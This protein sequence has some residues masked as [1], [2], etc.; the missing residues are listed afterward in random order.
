MKKLISRSESLYMF[1]LL[2]YK[3]SI[4]L[5]S[6]F[7]RSTFYVV[8]V[9]TPIRI[10]KLGS[11]FPEVSVN[12]TGKFRER[13]EM[14]N[15]YFYEFDEVVKASAAKNSDFPRVQFDHVLTDKILPPQSVVAVEITIEFGCFPKDTF[16]RLH[17]LFTGLQ[18]VSQVIDVLKMEE[19]RAIRTDIP[20]PELARNKSVVKQIGN[21]KVFEE[22]VVNYQESDE[23]KVTCFHT[24][25]TDISMYHS[26]NYIKDQTLSGAVMIATEDGDS[27][28]FVGDIE[29]MVGEAKITSK[30]PKAQLLAGMGQFSG[31]LALKAIRKQILFE[32][33]K[34]YGLGINV[35]T[36]ETTV[37]VLQMDF[38]K[39]V[40]ELFEGIQK[41]TLEEALGR[42]SVALKKG[43]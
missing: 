9:N 35:S 20:L 41:L 43:I 11:K 1:R 26:K 32:K 17:D 13:P 6:F 22:F 23:S 25:I 34:I 33:I 15:V 40:S 18:S 36:N 31:I 42:I 5:L 38:K 7:N 27:T 24:S 30:V 37:L 8:D 39:T 3:P 28:D 21:M 16:K 12:R 14:D 10:Q 2:P 19:N 29:G 4:Y